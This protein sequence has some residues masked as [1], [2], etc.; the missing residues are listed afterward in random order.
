MKK[1]ATFGILMSLLLSG[2]VEAATVKNFSAPNTSITQTNEAM[3]LVYDQKNKK[4]TIVFDP[5]YTGDSSLA[6]YLLVTPSKPTFFEAPKST[7]SELTSLVSGEIPTVTPT[8]A[9]T[10]P[11]SVNTSTATAN[12]PIVP[13][14]TPTSSTAATSTTDAQAVLNSILGTP[15]SGTAPAAIAPTTPVTTTVATPNP[16]PAVTVPPAPTTTAEWILASDTRAVTQW[17]IKKN[18]NYNLVDLQNFSNYLNKKD[19]YFT[20]VKTGPSAN[21]VGISFSSTYPVIPIRLLADKSTS[22]PLTATVYALSETPLYVPATKILVSKELGGV[23]PKTYPTGTA[24]KNMDA[25]SAFSMKGKWLT[26]S[27]I[28]IDQNNVTADLFMTIGTNK[29]KVV[30]G[31]PVQV[32][33]ANVK[34]SKAVVAEDASTPLWDPTKNLTQAEIATDPTIHPYAALFAA[35]RTLQTG[36]N[37]ADIKGL[38]LFLRDFIDQTITPDG[39]WGPKTSK[40]V[41]TFQEAFGLKIDGKV[42]IQTRGLIELIPVSEIVK[43]EQAIKDNMANVTATS[44]Q[45]TTAAA[46]QTTATVATPVI[47]TTITPAAPTP[48][49]TTNSDPSGYSIDSLMD[50]LKS[51][52]GTGT[53]STSSTTTDQSTLGTGPGGS[54]IGSGSTTP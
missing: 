22:G 27:D 46:I 34:T 43:R 9:A 15:T 40:A 2:V 48:D 52:D 18:L 49:T 1:I 45:T 37:G 13:A 6:A 47:P 3:L 33:A 53:S 10:I 7:F 20:L 19:S 5:S 16:A 35:K 29:L 24:Q 50:I 42:G 39:K 11:T 28:K 25:V 31:S 4:E 17:L 14:A 23:T 12:I 32:S 30:S 38:Q 21:L 8:P 41:S 54:I 36:Q 51:T 26:K 44:T